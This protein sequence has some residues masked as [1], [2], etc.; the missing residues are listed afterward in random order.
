MSKSQEY[1][2]QRALERLTLIERNSSQYFDQITKLYTNAKLQIYADIERILSKY[3]TD[4]GLGIDEARELLTVR[5]SQDYLDD[6]RKRLSTVEDPAIRRQLLNKVNAPAYRARISRL[7]AIEASIDT[8]IKLIAPAETAALKDSLINTADLSYYRT[9]YDYQVGTG[10]GFSFSGLDEETIQR[11]LRENWSGKDFS[12]RIWTNTDLIAQNIKDI[13]QQNVMTGRSWRR[14][15][16]ELTGYVDTRNA[17]AQYAAERLLRTETNHI[18]NEI[19]ASA[20]QAM[21]VKMY[22]FLATLDSRT[23]PICQKHDGNIDPDT[24]KEYTYENKKVGVNFPPLHPF[25]R[26]CINARLDPTIEAGMMR[27]AKDPKTG[28]ISTVPYNT[29]YKQWLKGLKTEENGIELPKPDI[30]IFNSLGAAAFR[31]PVKLPGGELSKL[32]EGSRITKVVTFAG[33]GTNKKLRVAE[34]L[35]KD[36][37]NSLEG[38]MHTRGEGFVDFEGVP[39]RAELHWFEHEE[40]G[41]IQMK[42]KRWFE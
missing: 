24:G 26:S 35:A 21:G 3:I 19:T 1:W 41:R 38:W 18:Y 25:C 14:C 11:A 6:L 27:R 16:Q 13:V 15:Q 10:L 5:E 37:N 4:A 31:D 42:V 30:Q 36:Y 7:Q 20:H 9:L 40:V 33:K 17:G 2:D 32:S 39:K 23:S 28:K 12:K 22:R 34:F 29:T 8:N